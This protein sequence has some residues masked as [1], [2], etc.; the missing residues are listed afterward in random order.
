MKLRNSF[1][2]R[3][4]LFLALLLLLLMG[5]VYFAVKTVTITVARDQAEEQL[6]TGTRVFERFM[7]LRWRRIQYGLNW[8]TND[9][10]FRQAALNGSPAQIEAA[11]QEFEPSIRGSEL[12]VLDLNGR[13]I[14][15]TLKGL[16]PR[17][18]LSLRQRL[19]ARTP[20]RA[21]HVDRRFGQSTLHDGP[22]RGAH[23]FARRAC[24]VGDADGRRV[25]PRAALV[26]QPGSVIHGP[27]TGRKWRTQQHPA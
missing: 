12:F 23:P 5:V 11:L 4:S 17:T 25:C 10:D 15:S 24:G 7:D 16:P 3:I 6:H 20:P 2:A 27:Q 19:E 14:T 8:L 18:A 1:Q 9:S 22:G 26:E 13:I 21:I